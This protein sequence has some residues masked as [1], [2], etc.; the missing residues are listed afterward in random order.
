MTRHYNVISGDGHLEGPPD[1]FLPY[2]AEQ[3]REVA[4]R[5]VPTP[6]GGDSW[7]VENQPLWHT[8]TNLTAG[9]QLMRRGKSY[10]AAD[11]S[12]STGA[13]DGAQRLREQDRDGIDAEVLFPPIFAV[14]AL[15]GISDAEAYRAIVQGYNS[16]LADAYMPVAPDRLIAMGVI[17]ARG[18]DMAV[19]ELERLSTLGF[20]GGGALG[21]PQRRSDAQARGR[22]LL[23][24]RPHPR[25]AR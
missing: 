25:N 13:G 22:P 23:G 19:E 18:I 7:L 21:V 4:P 16:Y 11:G 15:T 5:R 10:W 12:R 2:I 1:D 14:E 9:E 3:Y 24:D 6:G 8:G 20:R 17:P